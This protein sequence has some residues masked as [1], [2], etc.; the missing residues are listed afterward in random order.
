MILTDR[1]A[2]GRFLIFFLFLVT[3]ANDTAAYYVGTLLGRHPMAP[4][5]SPKKTWEGA[6]GGVLGAVAAAVAAPPRVFGSPGPRGAIRLG[7][8]IC[9][10]A[11]PRGSFGSPPHPRSRR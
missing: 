1:L 4:L 11:P 8:P 2:N 7:L 6:I 5:I 3:W 10:P 9:P